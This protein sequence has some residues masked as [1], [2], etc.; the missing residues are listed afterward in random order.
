MATAICIDILN[1]NSN[2]I[3]LF[4]FHL[5]TNSDTKPYLAPL[6]QTELCKCNHGRNALFGKR[7]NLSFRN[8]EIQYLQNRYL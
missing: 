3:Q 8:L 5:Q 1:I 2:L 7:N 6:S 4:W